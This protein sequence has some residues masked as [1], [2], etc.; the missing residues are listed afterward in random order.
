MDFNL[1]QQSVQT[2]GM[3]YPVVVQAEET[4]GYFVS[5]PAF[6]GCFTQGETVEAALY[7]IKEV[8]QLCV[9]EVSPVRVPQVSV[10]MIQ[11]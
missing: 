6:E 4:G 3:F 9:E 5:C 11:I 2:G 10:H 1:T 8:I 7:N